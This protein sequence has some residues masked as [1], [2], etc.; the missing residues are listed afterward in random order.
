MCGFSW[1][2]NY[3][4]LIPVRVCKSIICIYAVF[5]QLLS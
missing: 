1:E 3:D 5:H 4:I 2:F